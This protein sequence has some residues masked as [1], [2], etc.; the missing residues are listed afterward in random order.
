MPISG[1]FKKVF[2]AVGFLG[3]RT[4]RFK[5][6]VSGI[7]PAEFKGIRSTGLRVCSQQ[8]TKTTR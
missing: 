5:F 6:E 7:R 3:F 8:P 1:G 2:G 4:L